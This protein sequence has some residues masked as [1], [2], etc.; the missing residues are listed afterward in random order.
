MAIKVK[1]ADGKEE[2]ILADNNDVAKAFHKNICKATAKVNAN[3]CAIGVLDGFTLST[4]NFAYR[5]PRP[6]F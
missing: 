6:F 4:T 2:I 3:F 5:S 1:G